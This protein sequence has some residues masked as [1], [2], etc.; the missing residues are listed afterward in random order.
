MTI[1]SNS[2]YL[3]YFTFRWREGENGEAE[4]KG[5]EERGRKGGKRKREREGEEGPVGR[6]VVKG[7]GKG[8]V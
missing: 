5:E 7:E 8:E 3:S 6:R 4:R 2:F 1:D